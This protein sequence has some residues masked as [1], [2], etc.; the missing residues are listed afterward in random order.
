MGIQSL[1]IFV[2]CTVVH[3][4]PG[5]ELTQRYRA[6][7]DFREQPRGYEWAS[8]PQDVWRLKEFNYALGDVFRLRLGPSQ[9]VF[10]CHDSNVVW[11]A[12]FPEQAGEILAASPGN[13]E[14]VT[15][16]WLRSHP[17]RLGEL[18]PNAIVTG[19]GDALMV[20]QAKRLAAYKVIAC[21]QS[22][23]LPMIPRKNSV[24]FDLETREGPRRFYSLD[25]E[26]GKLLA[27]DFFGDRPL[28]IPKPLDSQAALAVFDKVWNAF[29]REYAMFAIKPHV[30]WPQL[31][32]TYR[33]RAATTKNNHDLAAVIS[34]M[35]DHLEDLHVYVE[36]DG[37]YVPGYNRDRPMN[38][39]P[40][41]TWLRAA[42]IE[43]KI[44]NQPLGIAHLAEQLLP[45]PPRRE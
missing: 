41:A 31:R 30:D 3:L 9:V 40:K 22:G 13:G 15:S 24:T 10:G 34:E 26:T 5:A 39:N 38:A 28:P 29:D 6:T 25:T 14:H 11:A 32:E 27:V 17:A 12:I 43:A 1:T 16:V 8:G 44:E 18:F 33:P 35:L 4:L 37:Q 21:W 45:L 19:Q 20:A 2:V 42:A 36:A 23:G 7:L